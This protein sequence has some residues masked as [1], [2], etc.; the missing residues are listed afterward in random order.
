MRDLTLKKMRMLSTNS[1]SLFRY[2]YRK[3]LEVGSDRRHISFYCCLGTL[4]DLLAIFG[5]DYCLVFDELDFID[6]RYSFLFN[7]ALP[8]SS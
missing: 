7:I 8:C 5:E 1:A 3:K 6:V 4:D 2:L